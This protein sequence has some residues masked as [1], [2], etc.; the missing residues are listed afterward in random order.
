MNPVEIRVNRLEFPSC[1][2]A[3]RYIVEEEA[4]VGNEKKVDTIA[5]ELRRCIP[6]NGDHSWVMYDKYRVGSV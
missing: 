5:K 2:A 1:K 4:K 6:K 3:A